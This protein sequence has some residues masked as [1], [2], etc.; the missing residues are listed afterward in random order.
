MSSI[1]VIVL[2]RFNKVS[3]QKN[4]A[5]SVYPFLRPFLQHQKGTMPTNLK[6]MHGIKNNSMISYI[7][8]WNALIKSQSKK[9]RSFPYTHF[10]DHF[11]Q[12][13]KDTIEIML[14]NLKLMRNIK[15]NSMIPHIIIKMILKSYF[16][17][18]NL[19]LYYKQKG[20]SKIYNRSTYT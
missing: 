1:K 3:R 20:T 16:I 8:T 12:Q 13:Q 10:W 2:G 17:R 6:P 7:S 15:N 19:M 4:T 11:L 18:V 9:T 5:I 14:T